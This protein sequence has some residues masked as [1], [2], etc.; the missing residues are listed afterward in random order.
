MSATRDD[1]GSD[2]VVRAAGSRL[3]SQTHVLIVE[4]DANIR[5]VARRFFER[6]NYHVDE[7]TDGPSALR[8]LSDCLTDLVILDLGLPRIEGGEV[9]TKIRRCS[10]VP[11]IA[12]T[13]RKEEEERIRALNLGADDCVVLPFSLPE[14]EARAR[15]I[16][17]RGGGATTATPIVHGELV[18]DRGTRT[19]ALAGDEVSMTRK[20]FDL[21]AFLAAA[22]EQVFSR[23]DLLEHVWGSSEQWQD[24]ST[25]TEH[26]RRIRLKIETNPDRPRW[27]ATVRGVGYRFCAPPVEEPQESGR[28]FGELVLLKEA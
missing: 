23:E 15:A 13:G 3:A 27:I 26:I 5:N 18:V 21:L 20:E 1:R 6:K 28:S 10:G 17:R 14:I 9:L 8:T 2:G 22:P 12:Y 24:R 11:V 25:V 19:V 7:A 4:D 16:L